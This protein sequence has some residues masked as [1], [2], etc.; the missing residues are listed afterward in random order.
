MDSPKGKEWERLLWEETGLV[1]GRLAPEAKTIWEDMEAGKLLS[2]P[3]GEGDTEE[4]VMDGAA[5]VSGVRVEAASTPEGK[6][7]FVVMG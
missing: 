4:M 1:L 3:G 5:V 2:A 6:E 7:E